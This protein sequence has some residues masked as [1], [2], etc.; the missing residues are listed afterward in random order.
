MASK[1]AFEVIWLNVSKSIIRLY[2]YKWHVA[3]SK[4]QQKKKKKKKKLGPPS[5]FTT[6]M[7][8]ITNTIQYLFV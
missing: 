2:I 7:T 3:S 8:V 4:L 5:P 6:K 1:F